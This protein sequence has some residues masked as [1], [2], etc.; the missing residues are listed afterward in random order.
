MPVP[1]ESGDAALTITPEAKNSQ[2]KSSWKKLFAFT[3]WH[4]VWTLLV[5]LL[6]TAFTAGLKTVLSVILGKAFNVNADIGAGRRTDHDNLAEISKWA[7]VLVAL[8][9]GT[10]LANTAFLA[11]WITFGELQANSVRHDI[12]R[13][14]LARE[15]AW[16]DSQD[17]GISSLLTRIQT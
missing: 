15:M 14:L 4:H 5:A 1:V 17:Q 16:F 3:R 13:S 11:L 10:W 9:A 6:A 7:T 2:P 12:F 8:G